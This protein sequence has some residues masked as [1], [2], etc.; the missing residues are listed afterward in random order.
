M[1]TERH[2][3]GRTCQD[4]LPLA[5]LLMPYALARYGWDELRRRRRNR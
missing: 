2:P 4:L 3:G 1:P 5:L